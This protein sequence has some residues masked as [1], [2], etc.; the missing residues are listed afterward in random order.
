[1]RI[2]EIHWTRGQKKLINLEGMSTQDR[3]RPF[4]AV[5]SVVISQ[6]QPIQELSV[7]RLLEAAEIIVSP[8]NKTL[9]SN[10]FSW[11]MHDY[12]HWHIVY[13]GVWHLRVADVKPLLLVFDTIALRFPVRP[14]DKKEKKEENMEFSLVF[15]NWIYFFLILKKLLEFSFHSVSHPK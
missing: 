5:A 12:I 7:V 6:V 10:S 8:S 11:K 9:F 2:Q 4:S 14:K 13:T 15:S 3:L 1:M